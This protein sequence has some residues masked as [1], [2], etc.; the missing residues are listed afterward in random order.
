MNTDHVVM[1]KR[2]VSNAASIKKGRRGGGR[3]TIGRR[4]CSWSARP[5]GLYTH[6]RHVSP[7]AQSPTKGVPNTTKVEKSW[8]A[9]V[10]E[11]QKHER[12]VG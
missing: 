7:G 6:P 10:C 5:R 4:S 8:K 9:P 12:G 3:D 2:H 1:L 11:E